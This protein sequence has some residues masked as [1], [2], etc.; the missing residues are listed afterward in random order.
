MEITINNNPVTIKTITIGKTKLTKQMIEQMP[1]DY[2]IYHLDKDNVKCYG[3]HTVYD[4]SNDREA[5]A[6]DYIL[7][8]DIIGFVNIKTFYNSSI[9][10]WAS[11]TNKRIKDYKGNFTL[12]LYVNEKGILTKSYLDEES[13]LLTE[14]IL[15]KNIEQ[16]YI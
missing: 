15:S 16:I 6:N 3:T 7:N 11:Q 12:I 2:F 9:N 10:T 13:F 14:D 4:F 1:L 5:I 8:G